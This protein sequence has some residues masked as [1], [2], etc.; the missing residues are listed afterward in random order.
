MPDTCA[1]RTWIGPSDPTSRLRARL[2][3]S[4]VHEGYV[5]PYVGDLRR[6]LHAAPE[7]GDDAP[8]GSSPSDFRR[9]AAANSRVQAAS[10]YRFAGA[11]QPAETAW[12]RRS[13]RHL[14]VETAPLRIDQRVTSN[15]RSRPVHLRRAGPP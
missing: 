9:I 13:V 8:Q 15:Q 2:G 14:V 1:V 5:V 6:R 3:H 7:L 12:C 4:A 10:R 11:L